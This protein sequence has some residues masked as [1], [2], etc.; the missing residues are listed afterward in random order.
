MRQSRPKLQDRN[1]NQLYLGKVDLKNLIDEAH[2]ARALWAV[3]EKVDFSR[4]EE[5]IQSKE[6]EAACSAAPPQLLAALWIYAY[7]LGIGSAQALERMQSRERGLRWL[8]ADEPVDHHTLSDF[9]LRH[10]EALDALF[11]QVLAALEHAGLVD[12]EAVLDGTMVRTGRR[13]Q[14]PPL[15]E[16][17]VRAEQVVEMLKRETGEAGGEE[18]YLA[19]VERAA[20]ERLERMQAHL[21]ELERLKRAG[22]GSDAG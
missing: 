19:A 12:L 5:Q 15:D 17:L 11:S 18:R 22:T 21:R 3:L 6:P 2:L 20:R 13:S 10:E 7:S 1:R 14:L 8:C 4:Y 16:C 9:R